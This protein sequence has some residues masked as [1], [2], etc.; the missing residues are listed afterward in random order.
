MEC[1]SSA[2]GAESS[3]VTCPKRGML[4]APVP[5]MHEGLREDSEGTI[6]VLHPDSCGSFTISLH[7]SHGFSMPLPTSG[8]QTLQTEIHESWTGLDARKES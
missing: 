5:N 2:T 7:S 8:I 4:T 6:S 1:K 3:V